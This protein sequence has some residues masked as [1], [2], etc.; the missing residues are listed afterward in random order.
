MPA[1]FSKLKL[2]CSWTFRFRF[3]WL[4]HGKVWTAPPNSCT[5]LQKSESLKRYG[6]NHQSVT[7]EKTSRHDIFKLLLVKIINR[8]SLP[9]KVSQTLITL[10]P[11]MAGHLNVILIFSLKLLWVHAFMTISG[12]YLNDKGIFGK[13]K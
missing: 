2:M 7:Y 5:L 12:I 8:L 4:L 11:Y 9:A 1:S 6:I 3:C 10:R 13:I